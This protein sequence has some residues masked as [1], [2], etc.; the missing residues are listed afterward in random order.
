M[1]VENTYNDQWKLEADDG[2]YH[3]TNPGEDGQQK[4]YRVDSGVYGNPIITAE[5]DL[6]FDPPATAE[7][8][9]DKGNSAETE[10]KIAGIICKKDGEV[11]H[12]FSLSSP[13]RP[14]FS[15][16]NGGAEILIDGTRW[17]LRAL[18]RKDKN[19]IINYDAFYGDKRPDA[20]KLVELEDLN[21]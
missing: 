10:E 1:K 7:Y 5:P 17:H 20:V 9:D 6:A 13:H 16:E 15:L 14:E 18:L 12:R 11:V 8:V 21:F 3:I 19:R 4:F 2:G